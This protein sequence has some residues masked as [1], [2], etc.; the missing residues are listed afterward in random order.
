MT[1]D[2]LDTLVRDL[3]PRVKRFLRNKLPEPDCYDQANE[4]IKVFLSANLSR[5]ADPRAYLWG[6]ARM[7]VLQSLQKRR[8]TQQFD[9]TLHSIAD[10]G[11]S[12]SARL[13]RRNMLLNAMRTLPLDHQIAFELRHVEQLELKEVA[14][15]MEVSLA[16]VKRYI[17]AAREELA[18]A[19]GSADPSL[20]NRDTVAIADAY[21]N[22]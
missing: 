19:L 8:P 11:T 13:D 9:S 10:L 2:S 22:S 4:V 3:Y 18:T 7:K 15:A 16:T 17:A 1:T 5:V 14:D 6:I 21:R 20:S 12:L